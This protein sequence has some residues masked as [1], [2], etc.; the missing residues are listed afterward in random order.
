MT[1]F[2]IVF[3]HPWLLLLLVPALVLTLLPYFRIAKKYRRTRNRVTSIVLHLVIM[4]LAIA[5]LSGI[6][7][8][9]EIKNKENELLLLVDASYSN[10][11]SEREKDDFIGSVI[12]KCGSDFK[13]GVV[14]F[15]YDQVYAA[16]LSN[17]TDGVYQDYLQSEDPDLTA[18]DVESALRYTSGL[19]TKPKTSKIVLIS[20]GIETDGKAANVINEIAARG[21]KVDTVYYPNS[22][23]A[24]V[25]IINVSTPNQSIKVG[26]EFRMQVTLKSNVSGGDQSVS[27]VLYDNEEATSPV[28]VSVTEEE[29][30]IDV[31]YKFTTPE[32][33][34]LRFEITSDDDTLTENNSYYSYI[35]LHVFD[36]IL[37]IENKDGESAELETILKDE[38]FNVTTYSIE[39][40]VE[41]I[42]N[43]IGDLAVFEQVVLVNIA[44]KDMPAGFED[45]LNKYVS[46]LG[47]G[48]FTVGG[49]N[50]VDSSGNLVPHAYNRDDMGQSNY[51]QKMLP[52][53]AVNYTPPIATMVLIDSSGSMGSGEGSNLRFAIDGA[54]AC[55]QSLSSTDYF[56]IATF[57]DEY[58]EELRVT[59]VS[60]Y[61]EIEDTI[62]GLSDQSAG[63]TVFSTALE[64]AGKALSRVDV[65][66]R[67]IIMVTDG[68]PTDKEEFPWFVKANAAM[69]ITMSVILISDDAAAEELMTNAATLGGGSCY[70][71]TN[72][73]K[74]SDC[75]A[76]DL[77]K[78]A[79]TDIAYGE[80]FYPVIGDYTSIFD[81]SIDRKNIPAL[82]GYYGTRLK[83]GA[84]VPLKGPYG[85]PIYAQWTYGNGT[86]G[87][88][89][90]DLNGTWSRKFVDS[91]NGKNLLFNIVSAI[92]PTTELTTKDIQFK[93]EEDNYTSYLNVYTVL[94]NT[95]YVE[96]AVTPISEDAIRFYEQKSIAVESSNGH[97]RFNFDITCPGVYSIAIVKKNAS[98][99]VLAETRLYKSFSYSS[100]YDAFPDAETTGE[101]YL[102]AL[103]ESGRGT[104]A[105]EAFEVFRSF[106]KTIK[107]EFDPRLLFAVLAIV[108]FLLDVA[109]RKFKFKWLHEIV[110]EYRAQKEY[111]K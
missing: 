38:E 19:F 68:A 76:Q 95:D 84:L 22:D 83:N 7:F 36:N 72:L 45:L 96:V 78:E 98:G 77:L 13:V 92:F 85:V 60:R 27:L 18:T 47:G 15:G 34:C 29:Q 49:E 4:A 106:S 111:V 54:S 28:N 17:D 108:L 80:E 63:G 44:Y 107:K 14:K 33:H 31:T 100:E 103:A 20:D 101:A 109:V 64:G 26:D 104:C 88:F 11:E 70:N 50:D 56:G 65:E 94:E 35:Y 32:M 51:Y 105:S 30:I 2:K 62:R 75:M 59:P 57:Q 3:S 87:S 81:S 74:L 21:I 90:C 23:H 6:T 58:A 48:L 67:H 69:G 42:P 9:Y 89:M 93:M 110:K 99:E 91:E 43:E 40:D 73:N 46:E 82:E 55:L 102:T 71:V 16:E 12:K 1:N 24:E 66:R 97:T 8:K 41:F 79:L 10:R 52:V 39:Q 25:Q 5:M 86:V 53:Q 37:I 61:E